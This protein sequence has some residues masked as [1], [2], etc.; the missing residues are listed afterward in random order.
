MH[1]HILFPKSCH[2][3]IHVVRTFIITWQGRSHRLLIT[4]GGTTY[5]FYLGHLAGGVCLV[6]MWVCPHRFPN[7]WMTLHS[8]KLF[9]QQV[10]HWQFWRKCSSSSS[11]IDFQGQFWRL[12]LLEGKNF[13]GF[14]DNRLHPL[15]T[16]ILNL[17]KATWKRKTIYKPLIFSFPVRFRGV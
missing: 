4:L 13:S 16:N 3:V 15:K 14:H 17:K 2:L 9:S 1:L 10:C 12:N 11:L 6:G 5:T 7:H 8:P